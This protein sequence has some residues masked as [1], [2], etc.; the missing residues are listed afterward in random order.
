MP[1]FV[2]AV[3]SSRRW[4]RMTKSRSWPCRSPPRGRS[5]LDVSAGEHHG[6]RLAV[7]PTMASPQSSAPGWGRKQIPRVRTLRPARQSSPPVSSRFPAGSLPEDTLV[8][9]GRLLGHPVR[10]RMFQVVPERW[11]ACRPPRRHRPDAFGSPCWT[12]ILPIGSCARHSARAASVS[13]TKRKARRAGAPQDPQADPGGR[14]WPQSSPLRVERQA[15]ALMNQSN[16]ASMSPGGTRGG[17]P[18][19]A[20][21]LVSAAR[22][23]PRLLSR[24]R[25]PATT[26][27]LQ[28]VRPHLLTSPAPPIGRR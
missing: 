20:I 15:L 14:G 16:I 7:R 12:Q 2:A 28:A 19:F 3:E 9:A 6:A 26:N 25:L 17:R 11:T 1:V 22:I 24:R 5:I 8:G 23:R 21:K 13:S 27:R 18:F 4:T 10:R